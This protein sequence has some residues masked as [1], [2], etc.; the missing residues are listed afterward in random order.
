MRGLMQDRPLDVAVV[1][2]PRPAG[3]E[4]AAPVTDD[5]NE[6]AGPAEAVLRVRAAN[7]D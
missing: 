6:A 7:R 1:M 3:P 5:E 4:S 2:R